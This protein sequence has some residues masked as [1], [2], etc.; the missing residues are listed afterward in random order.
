MGKIVKM[1]RVWKIMKV[2]RGKGKRRIII[3]LSLWIQVR[4]I[5]ALSIV[6]LNTKAKT[7]PILSRTTS[8]MPPTSQPPILLLP[9]KTKNPKKI[10]WNIRKIIGLIIINSLRI[11]FIK[12]ECNWKL[13]VVELLVEVLPMKLKETLMEKGLYNMVNWIRIKKYGFW[14]MR[15]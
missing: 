1:D 4:I 13:T 14:K 10:N 5:I 11:W 7:K 3:F 15:S 8:Q 2:W 9:I 12:V 6:Y